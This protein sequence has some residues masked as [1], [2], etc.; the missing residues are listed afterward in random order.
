MNQ[1]Q[2]L[3]SQMLK[4]PVFELA[5]E[6]KDKVLMPLLRLLDEHHR[7]HCQQYANLFSSSAES[8]HVLEQLPFLAV[9]LFKYLSLKSIPDSSVYR[10]L[11]S[12][13]TTAQVKSKILLDRDT[14]VRQSKVLVKIMQNFIGRQ[15]LPMLIVDNA[16]SLSRKGNLS[17][18]GAGVQGMMFLGRDYTYA[19]DENMKIDWRTINAFAEKYLGQPKLIFGF[20]SLIW[21]YLVSPL[22]HKNGKLDLADSILLHSGGWKK[23]IQKK[24][25]NEDFKNTLTN[26]LSVQHCH[27]FYGMAEQVGSVFVECEAGHLHT[28]IFADVIVR[29]PYNLVPCN[30]GEKGLIQVLSAIPTSYPGHSILTEDLGAVLGVDD[31]PC[32]RKGRYFRVYG[33]LPKTELRGCSDTHKVNI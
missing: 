7:Q 28:P 32:G 30:N 31:C 4:L 25:S 9:R 29:N 10:S 15:R 21:E 18:R 26:V 20:T 14:S 22:K 27:N 1:Y 3:F 23:L 19:L 11:T 13:G 17:A 2:E 24:V 8:N 6:E 16:T 12:S 5:Q 33:R